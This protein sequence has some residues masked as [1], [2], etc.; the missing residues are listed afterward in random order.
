MP[1]IE[2]DLAFVEKT[3]NIKDANGET[4]Q[5][6]LR[7]L[8]GKGRDKYMNSIQNRAKFDEAGKPIGA[9]NFDGILSG[10]LAMCLFD[11]ETKKLVPELTIQ[12]W[13]ARVQEVLFNEAKLLSKLEDV[14]GDEEGEA[15]ND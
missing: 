4:K 10:L 7:E 14:P 8:D 11:G 3:V 9:K 2:L 15:K 1:D 13:P 12:A 5:Y 6:I